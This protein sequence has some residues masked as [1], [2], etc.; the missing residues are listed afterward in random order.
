MLPHGT[1]V[2]YSRAG[3]RFRERDRYGHD[4]ARLAWREDGALA[5][6][7]VRIPDGTWLTIEPRATEDAPWGASDRLWRGGEALTVFAAVDYARIGSIPT[8]AEPARVP[9]GGG[10]AV[11]NLIA[12][13]ATDQRCPRLVY[14]GP[15]PGEQLFLALLESFRYEGG[16]DAPL[17]AFMRGDLAWVPTPHERLVTEDGIWIQMREEIEKVVWKGRPYYRREWQGIRRHAP[18][19]LREVDGR[20]LCSLEVLG[21]AIEDHL[22][23]DPSGEAVEVLPVAPPARRV[24]RPPPAVLG[25]VAAAVAARS[26]PPLGAFIQAAAEELTLEW[27]PVAQDLARVEGQRLRVTNRLVSPVRA[28]LAAAATSDEAALAALAAISELA[29]L[30]GDVL[31]ARGQAR[32]AALPPAGQAAALDAVPGA[33]PDAAA[34]ALA[35]AVQAL[36][37][38]PPLRDDMDDQLDV[39]GDEGANR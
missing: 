36:L 37:D 3:R 24:L 18:R 38:W 13:L 30:A 16:G 14:P 9:P 25:G 31:R 33:P 15:Y 10:T 39:E 21:T 12:S 22:R 34:R 4:L 6:A 20:I 35:G 23:I 27:G 28:R 2:T 1:A 29:H 26:A 7:S 5:E 11:L 8:L 32:L 19:C 17:A